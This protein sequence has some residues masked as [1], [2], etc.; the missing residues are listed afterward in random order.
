VLAV[1][2]HHREDVTSRREESFDDGGGETSSPH[3]AYHMDTVIPR[4]DLLCDLPCPIGR[5]IIDNDDFVRQ[6]M[7]DRSELLQEQ[8]KIFGFVVSGKDDGEHRTVVYRR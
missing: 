4:R 7:E 3:A 2:I 8:W 5:V 6:V 1:G